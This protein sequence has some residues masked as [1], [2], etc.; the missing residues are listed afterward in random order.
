MISP[1]SAVS[2]NAEV[3][4]IKSHFTID[5]QMLAEQIVKLKA[6]KARLD[7]IEANFTGLSDSERYLPFRLYWGDKSKT[8]RELIDAKMKGE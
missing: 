1:N 6:D 2:F 5:Y 8:L 7:F 3:Q 4:E